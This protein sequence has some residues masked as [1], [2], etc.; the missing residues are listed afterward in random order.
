[1]PIRIGN[2]D[3][4]LEVAAGQP[5]AVDVQHG[6]HPDAAHEGTRPRPGQRQ[7]TNGDPG[8]APVQIKSRLLNCADT[9]NKKV[10]L[11]RRTFNGEIS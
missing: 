7:R 8:N 2:S 3:D 11:D 10:P 4:W 9:N 5:A 1:V 6:A